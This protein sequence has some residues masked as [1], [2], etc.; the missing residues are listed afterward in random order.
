MTNFKD[1]SEYSYGDPQ[2]HRPGTVNIGWLGPSADFDQM[3]VD[4]ELLGLLWDHTK[5]SVVQYRG[6]H[7]CEH[8]PPHTSNVAARNGEKRLLGSAEIR[9]FGGDGVIY[10]APDLIYHY[11]AIH[12]YRPPKP[13]CAA[14]K[15]GPRPSSKDHLDRLSALCL[16]WTEKAALTSDPVRFRLVRTPDGLKKEIL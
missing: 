9:V 14:L 16:M 6:L 15:N 4:E 10:A 1:L 5:I 7:E 2:F 11:V 8:C 12:R 3:E 13:F